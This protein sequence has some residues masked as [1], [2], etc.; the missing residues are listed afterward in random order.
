MTLNWDGRNTTIAAFLIGRGPVAYVGKGWTGGV[1]M[2]DWDPRFD[3]D[4]GEPL[5]LCAQRAPGVF[6][7]A[8]T[9]GLVEL[10]CNAFTAV[11]PFT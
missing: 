5:G 3:F 4:V 8:W 2:M 11:L 6:E 1:G 9:K 10:D 7:R